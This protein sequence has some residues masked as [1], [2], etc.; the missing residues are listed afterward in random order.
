LCSS[1]SGENEN[2]LGKAKS[3]IASH[4]DENIS[5]ESCPKVYI[6]PTRNNGTSSQ[7]QSQTSSDQ[8][9]HT[10]RIKKTSKRNTFGH[11]KCNM[12]CN[13]LKRSNYS[14]DNYSLRRSIPPATFKSKICKNNHHFLNMVEKIKVD[15]ILRHKYD[16]C[17]ISK[18]E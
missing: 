7:N 6:I 17:E 2:L 15:I 12:C 16:M 10:P 13:R 18:K 5:V 11:Y 9:I 14:N 3:L 1:S 4:V 8:L